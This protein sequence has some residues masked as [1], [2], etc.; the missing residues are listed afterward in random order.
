MLSEAVEDFYYLERCDKIFFYL[1]EK[2]MAI[3][4]LVY[5]SKSRLD[6]IAVDPRTTIENILEVSRSRNAAAGITGALIF[7]EN[8]FTQVLEGD[9]R[10]VKKVFASIQNDHRHSDV[11]ILFVETESVRRFESWSMAFA[12][13]SQ[14]ARDHYR[15][16]VMNGVNWYGLSN[17]PVIQL[18]LKMISID[19]EET[20]RAS[21]S[22]KLGQLLVLVARRWR[23]RTSAALKPLDLSAAMV[24]PLLWL[25]RAGGAMRQGDLAGLIGVE[26]HSLTR[27]I[28]LL[29]AKQLL[30]QRE[31]ASDRRV[32][33]F[34]L[35][36]T[37]SELAVRADQNL[38][39]MQ[40]Q[41][42]QTMPASDIKETIR[43]LSAIERELMRYKID[44]KKA[45]NQ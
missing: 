15:N 44:A 9:E 43:L 4:R 36:E 24:E 14:A 26:S 1:N 13:K 40:S 33:I 41:L 42:L 10:A 45:V 37:G 20:A 16:V 29:Q 38:K 6:A 5:E 31:D 18:M 32:K 3:Y 17:E 7:N 34:Q 21:A 2:R 30:E 23:D 39:H 25:S 19:E 35:T 22:E 28:D 11:K 27:V 8:R 12:G